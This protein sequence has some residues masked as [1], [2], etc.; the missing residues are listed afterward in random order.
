MLVKDHHKQKRKPF[1]SPLLF[2]ITPALSKKK[3]RNYDSQGHYTGYTVESPYGYRHY[4]E[5]GHYTGKTT[6]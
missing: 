1:I 2:T 4:D 5:K 3:Y 6:K